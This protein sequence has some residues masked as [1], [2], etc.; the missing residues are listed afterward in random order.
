MNFFK[1]CNACVYRC[2]RHIPSF[3]PSEV[4]SRRILKQIIMR[5]YLTALVIT[6]AF[7]NVNA[8]VRAQNVTL[9]LNNAKLLQVFSEIK[10]QTGYQ[11]WYEDNVLNNSSTVSL[12]L[13]DVSVKDAVEAA[14]KN[15]SLEFTINDRTIVIREK[16]KGFFERVIG[17]F[18]L[19]NINGRITDET[20]QPLVGATVKVQ[21]TTKMVQTGRNGEFYM[22]NVSEDAMIEVIYLGYITQVIKARKNM[23]V[24]LLPSQENLQEVQIN[25][26]YY[27]IKDRERT[28]SISR[29]T[30]ETLTKQPVGNPLAALIGR[31]AGVNISQSSG[32]NGG[33]INIEIRGL[34][35]LRN[36]V[37]DNGNLPLYLIDGVPLPAGV[38]STLAS[39]SIGQNLSFLSGLNMNDI[40]SIEVLKDADATAIYGSRGSNGVVLITT[41][42]AKTGQTSFDVNIY[43]GVS[44][45]SNKL[46]L[47]DTE[48]YLLMR[49]E[50]FKNDG[51]TPAATDYD[52]NG[53]WNQNKY[54]DWQHVLIGGTANTTNIQTSLS[55]GN[56]STNFSLRT[57]YSKDTQVTPGD[58]A[59]RNISN[60]L[61]VN[62]LSSNKKF[63]ANFIANFGVQTNN[64]PINDLTS[65]IN[66]PPNAPDLFDAKGNLNWALNSSGAATWKNPINLIKQPYS[67]RSNKLITSANLSYEILPDLFLRTNAGYSNVRVRENI[68]IT[69]ASQAPSATAT[70]NNRKSSN[71]IETWIIEPQINYKRKIW[72]GKLDFIV[73]ATLQNDQQNGETLNGN[74]ITSDLLIDNLSAAPSKT[75]G[76]TSSQY[77]YI[78]AFGRLN[79][80]LKDRYFINLTGRRDGSSRFGTDRQF[81]NFGAIGLAYIFSE[82]SFI[83]NNLPFLSFGKLRGSYGITGN[84]QIPNYGYLETY[85]AT[86]V[87]LDGSGLF[88]SRIANPDYSWETNKKLEASVELGF[89]KDRIMLSAA[90]YRNRSSN[91]LVGYTLPD[92]TGFSSVQYNL[93]A[94]V[95]NTG[96]EFEAASTNLSG[97][98]NWKTSFNLTIPKNKLVA[99][100]NLA[101]STYASTLVVGRSLYNLNVYHY[102]GI[103]PTTGLYEIEDK[104][105]NGIY[106]TLDQSPAKKSPTTHL[107]GGM[108][109][110]FSYG[111]LSLDIFVQFVNKTATSPY[112]FFAAPGN[113]LRNQPT[114]VLDRWTTAG[115]Q[116]EF[117]K[118]S[119][120][121]GTGT[122]LQRFGLFTSSDAGLQDASYVRLKNISLSWNLNTSWLKKMKVQNLR[123]YMQGQNLLTFTKYMGDPETATVLSLPT[124]RTFTAGMQVSL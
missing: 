122:A 72:N 4:K 80:A 70:A 68:L 51:T 2:L 6:L 59:I 38:V 111:S 94:T 58:F 9:K 79:Y 67:N 64:L 16:Q 52:V 22:E 62:H 13:N 45:I 120:L 1:C 123:L 39:S 17:A 116:T 20:G 43:T 85:S 119:K 88:P 12:N 124:L 74:G 109:N 92:I 8:G 60:T 103:N 33:P 78:A 18:K 25:A 114:A 19:I 56:E 82:E 87:Y 48:Q 40:E 93:P 86:L 106:N 44:Q 3:Y 21:G 105:G 84:D 42:K 63:R 75:A 5:T 11:F 81:A 55:G 23:D 112:A 46:K 26:G 61:S 95:Q 14:I 101:G 90:W 57:G 30:G 110:S 65:A 66:L 97:K 24:Q 100:P 35:S 37:L 50:T 53:T 32:I 41:K 115:D 31:M 73:G 27:K 83:K 76:A 121:S 34:N 47:M 7:I 99:F 15:Q 117:Q 91:Q 54:T 98:F 89:L 77:K 71:S 113:G 36:T 118:Y 104:D 49:R 107:F 96:L 10:K 69:I 108:N 29:V 102:L 28:G